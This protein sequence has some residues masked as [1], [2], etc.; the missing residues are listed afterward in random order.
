MGSSSLPTSSLTPNFPASSSP[1]IWPG[2]IGY[3]GA[4]QYPASS[5]T[6]AQ[7]FDQFAKGVMMK[8][9]DPTEQDSDIMER[10]DNGVF[11]G[12]AAAGDVQL[13]SL[14][15]SCA[16]KLSFKDIGRGAE[17]LPFDW[18]RTKVEAL[19]HFIDKDFANF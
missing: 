14:G 17:T 7:Q 10:M 5:G 16:P 3:A 12:S 4:P 6:A 15:C 2:S 9:L 11:S 18:S 19:L 1:S 8:A 13:V